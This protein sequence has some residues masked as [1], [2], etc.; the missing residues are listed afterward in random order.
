MGLHLLLTVHLHGDGQGSA[1]YHGM[2][3]GAPEWPPAPA[4]VFQALVAGVARGNLL[5]ES[6]IPAFEWLERLDPPLIGAPVRTLGQRFSMF[7]PNNDTDSLSN[8]LDVSGLRVKKVVQPSLF[9]EVTTLLY[10][11][12]LPE[13][14]APA[15]TIV[16]AANQL[17]QL[18]R[19]V[20]MAWA[21]AEIVDDEELENRL[22]A[23]PG[24]L[25]RPEPGVRGDQMLLCPVAGSLASLIERHRAPKLRTENEGKAARTLFTNPPKPRF[26][27]VS[28]GRSRHRVVYELRDRMTDKPWPWKLDRVVKLVEKLRDQAVARLKE[29]L[30]EQTEQIER[31][32][33][34]RRPNGEHAGPIAHRVRIVPM[35]SI[36][37]PHADRAI[38]RVLIEVPSGCPVRA[39]D[40]EWAFSRLEEA[41][42]TTGES[43]SLVVVRCEGTPMLDHY[44][45]PSRHWRTVTP[46][47]LPEVAG[48]R[49]IDPAHRHEEAKGAKER[50]EEESRAAAAVQQAL[51]HADVRARA[52]RVRVQREP[53]EAHGARVEAFAEGTR[54]AKERLWHVELEL[55]R[56]VQGPL[57]I[58][59]GRFLGLGLLAPVPKPWHWYDA[60]GHR[61]VSAAE[62]SDS[63]LFLFSV[64]GDAKDEPDLLARAL[65]RAVMARVQAVVGRAPLDSFFSGHHENPEELSS[66]WNHLA[67]H[68]DPLDRRLLVIAPHVLERRSPTRRERT[69]LE[70]LSKALEGF[71][72]LRA[73]TAGRFGL[74][75]VA[76]EEDDPLFRPARSCTSLT[77]YLVTRHVRQN[78]ASQALVTDIMEECRRSNLPRPTVTVLDVRGVSGVGLQGIVR[79]DFAVAVEGPIALG[80]TRYLGGGLFTAKRA[81]A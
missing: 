13:N 23:Y 10:V 64:V 11:W 45:G 81:E 28:Y 69:N 19:G 49:R 31:T 27:S 41:E 1:R 24:A 70:I 61:T 16:E 68:W 5:P 77:P 59:D 32:L 12:S 54:F 57:V 44:A 42:P 58:G 43:S 60:T 51:R 35:P 18:G 53:F 4:R 21:R 17:Y 36:G 22:D 30:P 39:A 74:A 66:H 2:Y 6:V 50:L 37:S 9:S 71:A 72:E 73:G 79:L 46:V 15:N 7:V 25:H 8:P 55:D 52:L 26:V 29:G 3:Q 47:A 48:R 40:V 67:F 34:G 38:R 33:V 78:S 63:G 14:P 20:D 80:R 62:L 65:R 75:R 56:A 76:L